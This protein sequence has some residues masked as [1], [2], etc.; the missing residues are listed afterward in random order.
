[1]IGISF[2]IVVLILG[3]AFMFLR[4]GRRAGALFALPLISV[5]AF[6]LIG[7]AV[8]KLLVKSEVPTATLHIT[9]DAVGLA[10]GL[11]LCWILARAIDPKN[12]RYSYFAFCAVFLVAMFCA[13]TNYLL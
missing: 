10:A 2:A 9:I 7:W 13:Y 4:S 12:L 6:H 11:L 1:M 3:L 5:S 8:Y